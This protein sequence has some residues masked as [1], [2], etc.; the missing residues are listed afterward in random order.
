M[1]SA[2]TLTNAI[3]LATC[4]VNFP[5]VLAARGGRNGLDLQIS[6]SYSSGSLYTAIT[7]NVSAPTGVL[8]LGWSLHVERVVAV[9]GQS[10][11]PADCTYV[12]IGGSLQSRLVQVGTNSDGTQSFAAENYVFWQITYDP[13]TETW[14]VVDEDGTVRLFGGTASGNGAVDW[15]VAWGGWKGTSVNLSG[16]RRLAVGWALASISNR[17]GDQISYRYTQVPMA[18]GSASGLTFSQA[19]YLSQVVGTDGS[20]AVLGYAAKDAS[21][22]Q[23]P[24]LDPAPPNAWQDPVATNYLE[25]LDLFAGSGVLLDHLAFDYAKPPL[26]TGALTKR[27]LVSIARSNGD[28]TPREPALKFAYWDNRPA[29]V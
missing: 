17:F 27:L 9:Y 10:A 21:E 18:V 2:A 12:F 13:G 8:G 16:Q 4:Q 15:A 26:G 19:S 11:T 22:Y 28:G 20:K 23:N 5:I 7:D 29:T 6:A 14:R 3:D 24:H 25:T 1:L